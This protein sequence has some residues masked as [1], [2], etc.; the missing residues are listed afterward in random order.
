MERTALSL[1]FFWG[2]GVKIYPPQ[3]RKKRR[4]DDDKLNNL[5]QMFIL[6][7]KNCLIFNSLQVLELNNLVKMER[8]TK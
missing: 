5:H 4:R 1:T 6:F 8:K 7:S 2:L 3:R